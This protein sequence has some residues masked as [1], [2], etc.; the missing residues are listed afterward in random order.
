MAQPVAAVVPLFGSKSRLKMSQGDFEVNF[1]SGR[2]QSPPDPRPAEFKCFSTVAQGS[3]LQRWQ[4]E[5]AVDS[6]LGKLLE[7]S[8]I[9]SKQ[10]FAKT[11]R[12]QHCENIISCLRKACKPVMDDF[13]FLCSVCRVAVWLKMTVKNVTPL[14]Q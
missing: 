3:P 14:L 1:W 12:P 10:S 2:N 13:L 5:G 4:D 8:N 9:T 6:A 7:Y 11:A